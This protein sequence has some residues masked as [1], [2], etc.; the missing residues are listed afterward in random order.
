M[1][2]HFANSLKSYLERANIRAIDLERACRLPNATIA[3][4]VT[5][6]RPSVER[7]ADI[8]RKIPG[9]ESAEIL[10]AYLLDAVPGDWRHAVT[11]LVEAIHT[12]PALEQ[13][14]APYRPDSLSQALEALRS[15]A[16][17]DIRLAQY[18][19][20]TATIFNLMPAEPRA[21]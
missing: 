2:Q 20:D 5:G 3:K 15:A 21:D 1:S 14:T 17:G 10:R 13:A 11:I 8:L 12:N 4:L 9:D 6:Q 16:A 7:L 19:I 18:L